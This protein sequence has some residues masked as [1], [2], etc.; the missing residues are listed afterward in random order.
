MEQ[1]AHDRHV[2]EVKTRLLAFI[3]D[4]DEVKTMSSESDDS[5]LRT[6]AQCGRA[7]SF[8]EQHRLFVLHPVVL[9][10][11]SSSSSS[12][13]ACPFGASAACVLTALKLGEEKSHLCLSGHRRRRLAESPRPHRQTRLP[14]SGSR[15]RSL[16]D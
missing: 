15:P 4:G 12:S 9:P 8:P 3:N 1:E 2:K 5:L 13:S 6:H 14:P 11:S 16:S 7:Q 10:P